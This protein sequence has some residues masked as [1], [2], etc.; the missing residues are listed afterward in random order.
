MK[1]YVNGKLYSSEK[2][3]IV[4]QLG[5][6]DLPIICGGVFPLKPVVFFPVGTLTDE[7]VDELLEEYKKL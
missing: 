1:I 5:K 2:Q 6:E 4:F 3:A 7:D